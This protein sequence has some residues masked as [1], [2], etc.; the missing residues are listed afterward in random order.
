V[1][2]QWNETKPQLGARMSQE[3]SRLILAD[4]GPMLPQYRRVPTMAHQIEIM[5]RIAAGE[6]NQDSTPAW[7]PA[8]YPFNFAPG[9]SPSQ[10][11]K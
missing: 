4:S 9:E 11:G 10:V 8:A 6:P 5:E 7:D 3:M 1:L 2:N